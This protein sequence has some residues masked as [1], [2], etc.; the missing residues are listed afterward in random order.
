M[1][2]SPIVAIAAARQLC[3]R[4]ESRRQ[5][6]PL[7]ASRAHYRPKHSSFRDGLSISRSQPWDPHREQPS[8]LSLHHLAIPVII[9]IKFHEAA[10]GL[11]RSGLATT[12]P[13]AL[14]V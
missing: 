13:G 5:C 14:A 8:D 7:A 11:S 9:T 3:I 10:H 2:P 4:H 6:A 12:P 1:S